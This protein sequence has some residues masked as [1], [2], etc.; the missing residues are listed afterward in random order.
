V[1]PAVRAAEA[2]VALGL[3]V[4]GLVLLA[5]LASDSDRLTL[6]AE[7]SFFGIHRVMTERTPAGTQ[8]R[9]VHGTTLH[10]MQWTE[11]QRCDEPLGYYHRTGPAGDVF[12]AV[13]RAPAAMSIGVVGLGAGGLTPYAEPGQQWTYFEIDPAV[14]RIASNNDWFCFLGSSAVKPR[15]LLGDARLSLASDTTRYDLLVLDAY[16]SDAVPVH[17]LTREA[18]HQYFERIKPGGVLALHIS[19]RHFDLERVVAR[20][21]G[22]SRL[23]HRIRVD[24]TPS[25]EA[26]T[27]GVLMSTWAAVARDEA[28]LGPLASD[29]RWRRL[30][31][32]AASPLWTDD[33]SS[34]V[35]VLK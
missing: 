8:H 6:H 27:P 30:R 16:T 17:L 35:S 28:D 14:V 15:I 18:F 23:A 26:A 20:I 7:R 29:K 34:L 32:G 2:A 25:K 3:A 11:P 4:G 19:N 13:G 1:L 10:G 9:L 33:Y 12:A 24:G 5:P 22:D 21:V 31:L